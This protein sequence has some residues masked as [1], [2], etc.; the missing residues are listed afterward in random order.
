MSASPLAILFAGDDVEGVLTE[1]EKTQM[2]KLIAAVGAVMISGTILM[3]CSYAGVGIAGDKVVIP[4]NDDFL[5]GMLRKVYVC[6]LTA[7]GLTECV[8]GEPEA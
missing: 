6:K 4:R 1:R 8:A 2:K 7:E 3:G 5:Y